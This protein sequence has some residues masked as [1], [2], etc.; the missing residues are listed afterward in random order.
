MNNLNKVLE[1]YDIK[2]SYNKTKTMAT[3]RKNVRKVRTVIKESIVK[4]GKFLQM[5]M[6]LEKIYNNIIV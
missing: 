3:E 1:I 5:T 2:I 4:A 6:D